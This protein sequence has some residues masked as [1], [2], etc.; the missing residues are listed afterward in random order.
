M[1]RRT[2][3][4]GAQK[5]TAKYDAAGQGRRIKAWNPPST[6]PNRAIE[7][8]QR[9]RDRARDSTRNDWAG[10]SSVQK[11]A[12]NLVGVGVTPR[13]KDKKL[14]ALWEQHVPQAD[15]DGVLDAYGMQ[16]LAVR[17]WFDSGE[18]FLRRRPR[19]LA[20][21]FA[22]P[23]QYQLI[24]AD[25][26]P[27]LDTEA[28][29]GMPVGNTMRQG[30]ERNVYGRR[31]AYWM[32]V[33]HP[34]DKP[35][36]PN[37]GQL[38]R[39]LASDVSHV[40]E[41]K[42]PGQ[43]RGVSELASVLVRLR[44]TMD[45]EDAVLDRQKLANLFVAFITRA[46]PDG[47]DVDFDPDTGLPKWYNADGQ[48][49]AG[50]EPGI[51]QELQPGENVTFANPPE[52]GTT[53]SDYMRSTHLGTA[54]GSGLPYEIMS[55]DIQNV[56]DRTL[57]VV[58]NEFRRLARQRQWQ[59]VIP[60][61][62]QP[63]IEWFADAAVLSGAI[64]MADLPA[65]K[66]PK[67]SPEGWEYIHPVQDATGKATLIE[68]GIISR[69]AVIAERGDDP[70]EVDAERAADKK[71]EDKLGLTP[72]VPPPMAAPPLPPKPKAAL[73]LEALELRR[74]TAEVVALERP[75]AAPVPAE[76]TALEKT[77][78]GL[79]TLLAQGQ[80]HNAA[81]TKA[82]MSIAQAIAE[83]DLNV[84]VAAPTVNL[85][86]MN[87]VNEV[88]PTPVTVEVDVAAP[89]VTVEAPAVT[90]TNEVQP[91]AVDVSVSLPDR[92]TTTDITRDRDGNIVDVVQTETTL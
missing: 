92:R 61:I 46:M 49:M 2:G 11:W 91:A 82:F 1:T 14:Q 21:P 7:G 88:N 65:A 10:A 57:R 64:S 58:I 22:V 72:V 30:I 63:M 50:L 35:M 26:V 3:R 71:R 24:E 29:P 87:V 20:L 40:F 16:T 18:V 9:I 47:A 32:Y 53:Y 17:S 89:A 25:Y 55:G 51:M 31:T 41:P 45:F 43:L 59:I 23:V 80:E 19:S 68:A 81:I 33:D 60:M 37:P 74:V 84:N 67:H 48:P 76:P 15:A 12:T 38:I 90:I 83:R 28:W 86:D 5:S 42:R 75:P 77:F 56:S 66:A 34:G 27:M 44:S 6:G 62:C 73:E 8:V 79:A 36:R 69:S 78:A 85:G 52:A 54:A 39:V 13:W 70:A 4:S